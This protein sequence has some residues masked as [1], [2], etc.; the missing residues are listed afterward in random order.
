MALFLFQFLNFRLK[1][2]RE[3]IFDKQLDFLNRNTN[4]SIIFQQKERLRWTRNPK[5]GF[6]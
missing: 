6:Q 3:Y 2:A 4:N 5:K 1:K